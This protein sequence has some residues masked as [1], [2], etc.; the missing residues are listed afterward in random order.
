MIVMLMKMMK[1]KKMILMVMAHCTVMH[2]VRCAATCYKTRCVP[3]VLFAIALL[4]ERSVLVV[5][6]DGD[7]EGDGWS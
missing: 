4:P 5:V 3:G 7:G 1:K 2:G 6:F